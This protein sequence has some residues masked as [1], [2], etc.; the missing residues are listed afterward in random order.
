VDE[1]R[2]QKQ[3]PRVQTHDAR[4]VARM[5]P[6]PGDIHSGRIPTNMVPVPEGKP[7]VPS[8]PTKEKD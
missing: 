8:P 3:L 7:V 6:I 4:E 2:P 5:V 1:E